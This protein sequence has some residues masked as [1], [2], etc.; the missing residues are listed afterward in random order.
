M[1]DAWRMTVG[2]RLFP[3]NSTNVT[4][5]YTVFNEYIFKINPDITLYGFRKLQYCCAIFAMLL[6]AISVYRWTREFWYLPYTLSLFAFTGLDVNGMASNFSY[7]VYPHLFITLHIAL[8]LF[9]LK[10]RQGVLRDFLFAVSGICLW[11]IGFSLLPLSVTLIS[12]IILWLL[13][14]RL[15]LSEHS[16]SARDIAA[17]YLPAI[18][19]WLIFLTI[20]GMDF[21]D[22]AYK[23]YGYISEVRQSRPTLFVD[24]IP[25]ILISLLLMAALI[26]IGRRPTLLG[27][28]IAGGLSAILFAAI[29]TNLF[30]A[31]PPFWR[32]WFNSQ[33]WLASLVVATWV[34]VSS[35]IF[36]QCKKDHKLDGT[37]QSLMVLLVPSIIMAGLFIFFSSLGP[38][39]VLFVSIPIMLALSVFVAR[40]VRGS[41]RILSILV[42]I[43]WPYYY[44][45][46]WADW[47]FTYFD[48]PPRNLTSTFEE[49]FA[50]GIRTNQLYF[51][52]ASW[53]RSMSQQYSSDGDFSIVTDQAPMGYML[54]RRRPA[55]NHSWG[56]LGNSTSLRRDAVAQM[57]RDK[58]EPKI[59]FRFVTAPL[60]LPISIKDG[61][62][63][64]G[65]QH[66]IDPTDPI[67]DYLLGNM[68]HIDSFVFQQR[69]WIELYVR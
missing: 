10:Q 41:G 38:L 61:N 44:S 11:G 66:P 19:A 15:C 24:S 34:I 4:F 30:G 22:A 14:N 18:L 7:Y 60:F 25:Y 16:F 13:F 23:M 26:V 40:W 3:D 56:G 5:L 42:L 57:I 48:L 50:T 54:I 55:L 49:G 33:M 31:V 37:S 36:Y 52:M 53:M 35:G 47:E 20:N 67:D 6:L 45:M 27:L 64:L 65:V 2:D 17:L 28:G 59:A 63:T 62:Y 21:F 39:T 68:K 58:R 51:S 32:G 43:L 12:P 29:D 46:A 8:L 1:T 9:A 69:T